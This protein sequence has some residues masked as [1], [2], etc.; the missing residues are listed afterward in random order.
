MRLTDHVTVYFN[1]NM[2]TACIF[3]YRKAFDTTWHLGLQY[4]SP[5]FFLGGMGWDWVYLVRRPLTGLWYQTRWVWSSRW[6]ENLQG[7]P[8]YSEKTCP[9]ATLSTTNF[10][11]INLG[12]NPGRR[13]RKPVTNSLSD[14][15]ANKLP[16]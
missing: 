4:K 14:G 11:W 9:S 7:K 15:T 2:S 8:K 12:S 10:T 5:R 3:W 1:D 6:N 13:G 16:N